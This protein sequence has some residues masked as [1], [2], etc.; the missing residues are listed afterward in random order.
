[1]SLTTFSFTFLPF[2]PFTFLPFYLFS[3]P[4]HQSVTELVDDDRLV[5]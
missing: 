2:Y 4:K 5:P 1:M 3:V